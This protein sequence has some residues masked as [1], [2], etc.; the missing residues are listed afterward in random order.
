MPQGGIR[1]EYRLHRRLDS[2]VG[3]VVT[4]ATRKTRDDNI[5]EASKGGDASSPARPSQDHRAGDDSPSVMAMS[6]EARGQSVSIRI[7]CE[8]RG[9]F[10][11]SRIHRHG[12][13]ASELRSRRAT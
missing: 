1:N 8:P 5:G 2:D 12:R 6:E 11:V 10:L 4:P 7:E 9:E 3:Q 13:R